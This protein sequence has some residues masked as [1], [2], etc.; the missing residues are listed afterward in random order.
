MVDTFKAFIVE[1]ADDRVTYGIRD[2]TKDDLPER[3]VIIR[4][5]YS[6]VNYKDGLAITGKG[7]IL[8][9]FPIVPGVDYAGVVESSEA[10]ELQPGQRVIVNGF[11]VGEKYWGGYAQYAGAK[12]G[13]VVPLPE[14]F[15]T[16]QAM[17]IG[18]AGYTAMLCVM[19]LEEQKI[20][21][22]SGEIL[23]TGA[24]GGVGSVAVAVLAKLGYRV[25]AASGRPESQDYLKSLGAAGFVSREELTG[26]VKPLNKVRWAGAVDVV[27]GVTLANVLSMIQY[28]G[29]VAATGLTG[30]GDL[31]AT[32]Y[33]F[34][35]R[36]VTLAGVDSVMCPKPRRIE[37][38]RRL[39]EDL[40]GAA[41]E[42]VAHTI[43]LDGIPQA[44]EDIMA[45]RVKGRLVIDV[46][47]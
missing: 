17:A 10:P 30:G 29:V 39:A 40:P 34:I 8:K 21:P 22:G 6:S 46:N 27:G 2:I 47:A 28:G 33:P 37:A 31:P 15:T 18:T 13:W 44:A 36:N 16:W 1:K 32:V 9:T 20:R 4:V 24:S 14:R 12:A 41:I 3:E 7:P 5:D 43:P 26:K 25:I 35:L 42:A 11:E 19:T 23:V 38:W 45:N